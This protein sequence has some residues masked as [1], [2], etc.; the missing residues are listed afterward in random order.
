MKKEKYEELKSIEK[1]QYLVKR[2]GYEEVFNSLVEMMNE[3]ELEWFTNEMA[4]VYEL[5]K[6]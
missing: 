2:L 6:D 3:S 4:S 5:L 1:L